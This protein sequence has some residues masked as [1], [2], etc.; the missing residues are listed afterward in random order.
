[1]SADLERK[2]FISPEAIIAESIDITLP[3]YGLTYLLNCAVDIF[4]GTV[5]FRTGNLTAEISSAIS[6]EAGRYSAKIEENTSEWGHFNGNL[7]TIE[8]PIG[9]RL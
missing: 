5:T 1:M 7:L 6:G 4:D 8:L 9:K 3:G 2:S